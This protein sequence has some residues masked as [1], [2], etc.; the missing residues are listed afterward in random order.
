ME[1]SSQDV[2]NFIGQEFNLIDKVQLLYIGST[3]EYLTENI[4]LDWL[5]NVDAHT[6]F[7]WYELKKAQKQRYNTQS[8]DIVIRIYV[9]AH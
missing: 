5:A 9:D 4:S 7:K 6:F 1:I 8:Y 3:H 2:L